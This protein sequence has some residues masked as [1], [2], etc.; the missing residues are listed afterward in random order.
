MRPL[1][2]HWRDLEAFGVLRFEN[3]KPSEQGGRPQSFA[4]LNED[5]AILLMAYMKNI[6]IVRDLKNRLTPC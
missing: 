5:Q 6:P 1:R 3:T 2:H 4:I